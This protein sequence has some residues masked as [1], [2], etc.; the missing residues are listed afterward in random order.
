[1]TA[2]TRKESPVQHIN[3][4]YELEAAFAGCRLTDDMMKCIREGW[5]LP[6]EFI[7]HDGFWGDKHWAVVFGGASKWRTDSA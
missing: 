7:Y 2:P 6:T 3:N 1:M 5:E 4:Y